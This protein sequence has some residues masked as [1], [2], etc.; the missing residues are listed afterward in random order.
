MYEAVPYFDGGLRRVCQSVCSS[1][2][3]V[4]VTYV[5]LRSLTKTDEQRPS[6]EHERLA[7]TAFSFPEEVPEM[8]E[9][10][11]VAALALERGM[12][13]PIE[14]HVLDEGI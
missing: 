8:L 14:P 12:S 2:I 3:L 7:T 1:Q 9:S 11:S 5:M 6:G 4:L 13:S 10:Q